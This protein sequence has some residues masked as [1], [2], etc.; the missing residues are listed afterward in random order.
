[1][2]ARKGSGGRHRQAVEVNKDTT[3]IESLQLK[4]S[5]FITLNTGRTVS[6]EF[7]EL[8]RK[9]FRESYLSKINSFLL[10]LFTNYRNT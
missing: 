3:V 5:E 1:M 2:K 7:V 6:E 9:Q 4:L 8:P 10:N